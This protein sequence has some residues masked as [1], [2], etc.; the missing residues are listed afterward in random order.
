MQSRPSTPAPGSPTPS[1]S[2]RLKDKLHLSARR[3]AQLRTACSGL[4]NVLE[5]AKVVADNAGV[6]GL[7]MGMSGLIYVLDVAE[8]C[9]RNT[10]DLITSD[11]RWQENG[12]ECRRYRS[13]IGSNEQFNRHARECITG[14]DTSEGGD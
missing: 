3:K 14:E 2:S 12:T 13:I 11:P 9:P 10:R 5:T 8:V 7:S 6:P 4:K 1:F